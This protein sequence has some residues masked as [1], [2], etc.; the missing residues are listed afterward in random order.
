[1]KIGFLGTDYKRNA[2]EDIEQIYLDDAKKAVLKQ[3]VLSQ[4]FGLSELVM[5][6]TCNRV[7]LYFIAQDTNVAAA[8]LYQT[9]SE[10]HGL[11]LTRVQDLLRF[12]AGQP[13]L[14][15]LCEVVAGAQSMVFGENEILGQ[16]KTAYAQAQENG[17]TQAVLNKV[18]Q[19]AIAIGKRIRKETS[20]SRGSYSI[21]SIAVEAIRDVFPD[22]L[23][24][25]ILIIGVGTMGLRAVKKL[26]AL[27]HQNI[28]IT[29]RTEEKLGRICEKHGIKPFPFSFIKSD[30]AEFDVVVAA[31]GTSTYLINA[32][33][34]STHAPKL[35]IDLGLPRNI[36]PD[37][38]TLANT[39]VL[40]LDGL[41]AVVQKT[42]QNRR[43]ES[44][45]IQSIITD[46]LN[47][48]RSWQT[49]RVAAAS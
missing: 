44:E 27:G 7:E 4:T 43:N 1:M 38:Q 30:L 45:H 29:N 41:E 32:A 46:E 22:Y 18:F 17:L 6:T 23:E 10:L 5:L 24:H 21:S 12:D 9:L 31:T 48:L 25:P 40:T 15:H 3:V 37:V 11:P 47:Q 49:H 33:Q 28:F 26:V 39:V 2:L 36:N 14:Q 13:V 16:V 34:F 8:G 35:F 42:M 19:T 20:I